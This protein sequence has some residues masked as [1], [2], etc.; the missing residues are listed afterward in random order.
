MREY[1][2]IAAIDL[3]SNSFRLQV[4]RVVGDQV[5]PLDSLKEP[6]R[7]G[8]GLTPEKFLDEEAQQ[9]ALACLKLFSERLRG[10]PREAVRVVGTNTFRVAKNAAPF[11][12]A[13]QAAL[14]FPIEII[15]GREEAR[16]IYIGVAHGLPPSENKRLVVDIGGGSTEF[17]VGSGYQPERME[18]LYMGCVSFSRRF[19][20]DGKITRDNLQLAEL[21]ACS[22]IQTITADFSAGHWQQAIGSSGTARA[23]AEILEQNGLSQSGL[24]RDGLNSLRELL[25][26]SGDV[27]LLQLAGLPSDRVPVLAGGF[28]IMNS[29]FSELGIDHMEVASGAL[30]EGVLYDLLGRFHHRDMRESTVREF[31]RRYHVDPTQA[32]RVQELSD[33]LFDQVANKL[34]GYID[35]PRQYLAWAAR[36]HETGISIAHTGYHRH[37]AYIL[38][39]A[40]MPGFST[41]E[42]GLLSLLVR[43]HRGS[44]KKLLE[45]MP[46]RNSDE[47]ML[48]L[49]LRLAVLLCRSRSDAELPA[50]KLKAGGSSFSLTIDRNWLEH[51]TLTRS[52]LENEIK[53]LKSVGIAFTIKTDKAL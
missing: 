49:V 11:L 3:G 25:L 45:Q 13:A 8:A 40:D 52:L 46:V 16:L 17:I 29:I 2:T 37:S 5:Y 7:L 21:A 20:P 28:A 30:R 36:L 35:A 15:A 48:I 34:T 22:E 53:D 31:M 32:G 18:S 43:A 50:M 42:Q 4:A 19:F 26:K 23:L 38:A 12:E 51:N 39:N 24:T 44:L 9:R 33:A 10:L 27:K 6:V 1:S 14:G 47:W 41:R